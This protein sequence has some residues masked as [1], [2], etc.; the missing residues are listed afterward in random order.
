M[1]I[2]LKK[3]IILVAYLGLCINYIYFSASLSAQETQQSTPEDLGISSFRLQRVENLIENAIENQ[4]IAGAVALIA[5]HGEIALL[6]SYGM[7]DINN[8]QPMQNN[9]IFRIASMTKPITSLAIMM[10]YEEGHFFLNDPI[11]LFLP[12]LANLRVLSKQ[13]N[14]FDLIESNKDITIRQLLTHTSGISYKFI[15]NTER[16]MH[17]AQLY[18]AAEISDGLSET[19]EKISDLSQKLGTLPLLFEPGSEYAYGLSIDVLGHLIEVISGLTLAEFFETKIFQP[20]GMTDTHFYIE[21][22]KISRLAALYTPSEEGT[23]LEVTERVE[24]EFISFSPTYH[25]SEIQKYYSGGAGLV[26]TALDYFRLL[27]M[28]LNGGE[29]DGVRLL[30]P[31]TVKMMTRNNIGSLN[32]SPGIKFGLGFAV[33][34]EPSMVGDSKTQ[35]TYYW[36]G[37]F[38][39]RFFVDP[40]H[41]LIGIFLSQRIPGDVER[42]RDKFINIVYQSTIQ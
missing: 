31:T 18:S 38:N 34:E 11:S 25:Q 24:K 35:G 15:S 20:L 8:N 7:A 22:P 4:V 42:L 14:D 21:E 28:F 23:I 39:T 16:R 32:V 27:Q 10:L 13:G 2:Y 33:V 6:D 40:N 26:S 5:R 9:S 41:E 19:N 1:V 36:G 17:L 3:V 12:E 37:I 29:L 30:S